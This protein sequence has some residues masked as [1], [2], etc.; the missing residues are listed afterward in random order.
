MLIRVRRQKIFGIF[1]G[2]P[3]LACEFTPFGLIY[4]QIPAIV[5]L[6]G[7]RITVALMLHM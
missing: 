6:A 5:A 2:A 4:I 3:P 7:W 1:D